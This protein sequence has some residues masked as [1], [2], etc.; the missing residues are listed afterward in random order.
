MKALIDTNI[1]I[2]IFLRRL[3]YYAD[4]FGLLIAHRA[5]QFDGCGNASSITDIYYIVEKRAYSNLA[6]RSVAFCIRELTI[7]SVD[8]ARIR[9]ALRAKGPDFEDNVQI[10]CAEHFEVD[11]IITRNPYDFRFSTIEIFS[12]SEFVANLRRNGANR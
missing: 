1:L 7:L 8:E 9:K 3:D 6:K 5:G 4:S 11:A 2:D 12:A 10:A